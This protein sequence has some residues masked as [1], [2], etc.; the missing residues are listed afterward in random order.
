MYYTYTNNTKDTERSHG[1][2]GITREEGLQNKQSVRMVSCQHTTECI[3]NT[4]ITK[5]NN[6]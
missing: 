3:L 2:G 1:Y 4:N 6:R 5:N